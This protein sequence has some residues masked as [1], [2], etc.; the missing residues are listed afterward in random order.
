[1]DYLIVYEKP[2][3]E[4]FERKRKSYPVCR[5]GDTTNNGWKIL[6]IRFLYKGKYI[7]RDEYFDILHI[8]NKINKRKL[9]IKKWCYENMIK[10]FRIIVALALIQY[11]IDK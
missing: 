8:N 7:T 5:V 11:I 2:T 1:M 3:G 6:E 10:I 4:I 9:K